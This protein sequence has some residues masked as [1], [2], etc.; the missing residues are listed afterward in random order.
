MTPKIASSINYTPDDL[1]NMYVHDLK[2]ISLLTREDEVELAKKIEEGKKKIINLIVSAP[3]ITNEILKYPHL[4]KERKLAISNICLIEKDI[5]DKDEQQTQEQFLKTIKSLRPVVQKRDLCVKK[6]ANKRLSKEDIKNI[7][8]QLE[9]NNTTLLNKMCNLH[10]RDEIIKGFLDEFKESAALY[11]INSIKIKDIKKKLKILSDK[12]K[13]I[14]FTTVQEKN[15][16]KY[17]KQYNNYKKLKKE[18]KAIE[19]ELGLAGTASINEAL[20][21][22]QDSETKINQAKKTF[23]EANLRLVISIAKKH[24]GR[25]LSLSDLIQEGNIG[26]MTAVDKFDYKKGYKLSTYAFWWIRQA[27]SRAL[28]VQARTIRLPVHMI[29]TIN[30]LTHV[31]RNF[32]QEFSREPTAEEI[33]DE[34]GISVDKIRAILKIYKEPLS[35][36]TPIG[37]DGDSHLEDFIEDKASVVM[38]D[39]VIQQE[40]KTQVEKS[41][42]SLTKKE[43][44]IIKRRFGIGDSAPQSLKEVGRQFKVTRERIRQLEGK[45]LKKLRHI[46]RSQHLKFFLE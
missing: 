42:H 8:T 20:E 34:M 24:I 19:S 4:L 3:L 15:N 46:T 7:R 13:N 28:A 11:N 26:L 10:L 35:L 6:L 37:N 22:L 32:V 23:T 36:E 31:S 41:L 39:T 2:L 27:I 1:I 44:E 33:A 12:N 43:A 5:E 14:S 38:L 18:A 17:K 25:G 21:L 30:R 16:N 29:E 45:A 9:K 40:L